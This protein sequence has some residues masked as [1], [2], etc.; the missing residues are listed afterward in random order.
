MLGDTKVA[1]SLRGVNVAGLVGIAMGFSST[2]TYPNPLATK[3]DP[4]LRR[5][6]GLRFP[7]E[8]LLRSSR[9][10]SRSSAS[11]IR[12]QNI[13]YFAPPRQKTVFGIRD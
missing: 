1:P 2:G 5:F 6:G 9:A 13:I 11:I 12:Q 3:L 10:T 7:Y 8:G 4:T